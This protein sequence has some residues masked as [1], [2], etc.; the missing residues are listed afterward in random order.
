[1]DKKIEWILFGTILAVMITIGVVAVVIVTSSDIELHTDEDEHEHEEES[2]F[3][4]FIEHLS[5]WLLWLIF[6][7]TFVVG[8]LLFLYYRKRQ[9]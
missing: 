8:I 2:P 5:N 9:I 3:H 6:S 1:M 7:I 4:H